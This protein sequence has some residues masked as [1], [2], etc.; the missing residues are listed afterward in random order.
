MLAS[1]K[2]DKED[3]IRQ[4]ARPVYLPIFKVLLG[5]L[6]ANENF[7]SDAFKPD[8]VFKKVDIQGAP[9]DG[10]NLHYHC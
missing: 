4:R 3:C 5:C 6:S 10:Y 8:T 2:N 7:S 1:T 9:P